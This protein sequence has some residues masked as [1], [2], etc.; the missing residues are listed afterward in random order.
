MKVETRYKLI[1]VDNVLEVFVHKITSD[2]LIKKATIKGNIIYYIV[3]YEKLTRVDNTIVNSGF[4]IK[5]NYSCEMT[6]AVLKCRDKY[7][8][9][10]L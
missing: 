5:E 8:E 4:W 9:E 10:F 7:P 3:R 6:E 1:D 2:R